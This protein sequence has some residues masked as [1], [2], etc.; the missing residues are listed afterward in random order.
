[1]TLCSAVFPFG[2]N[3][4]SWMRIF[5]AAWYLIGSQTCHT[6][7][8]SVCSDDRGL[9]EAC[10]S[11]RGVPPE[12]SSFLLTSCALDGPAF[13]RSS[14][15]FVITAGVFSSLA[16]SVLILHSLCCLPFLPVS[17]PPP[18]FILFSLFSYFT[19]FFFCLVGWIHLF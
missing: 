18:Y 10:H 17:F 5:Q 16:A 15:C 6:V 4:T 3:V 7:G 8:Q 11:F 19:L 12:S 9:G 1:M 2:R 14:I 13:C